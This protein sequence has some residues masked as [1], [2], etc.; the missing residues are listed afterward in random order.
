ML[1]SRNYLYAHCR[2][3]NWNMT[4]NYPVEMNVDSIYKIIHTSVQSKYT[5][6]IA[7]SGNRGDES[8]DRR[9]SL[10]CGGNLFPTFG[11]AVAATQRRGSQSSSLGKKQS[12]W[13]QPINAICVCCATDSIRHKKIILRSTSD[14]S[15]HRQASFA[16]TNI[17][18]LVCWVYCSVTYGVFYSF[19]HMKFGMIST[20]K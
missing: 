1:T 2:D 6:K 16:A 10:I 13:T 7:G 4:E 14:S 18:C 12:S 19:N 3:T 17:M 11:F 8:P 5:R 20:I 9:P 15:T